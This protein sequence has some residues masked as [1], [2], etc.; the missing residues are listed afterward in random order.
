MIYPTQTWAITGEWPFNQDQ[1]VLLNP[2]IK[3]V[4]VYFGSG[5]TVSL[6]LTATENNGVFVHQANVIYIN[7]SGE[8]DIDL[9]VNTAMEDNFPTAI[10]TPP[11]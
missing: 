6:A 11:L 4:G 5:N 8:T 3:V 10:A 9:V 1:Y 7:S 2:K